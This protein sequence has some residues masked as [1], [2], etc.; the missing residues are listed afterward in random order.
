MNMCFDELAKDCASGARQN[1]SVTF[2]KMKSIIRSLSA[3]TTT[4][5]DYHVLP[6]EQQSVLVRLQ[7]GHNRLNSLM[8]RKLKL[9]PSPDCPCGQDEQLAEHVLQDCTLFEFEF[10]FVV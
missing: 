9:A 7:T 6:R 10:E 4:K 1:N 8:Y 5:D 2:S 3:S